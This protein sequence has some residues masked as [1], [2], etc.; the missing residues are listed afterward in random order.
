MNI[1][2]TLQQTGLYFVWKSF[3]RS[4]FIFLNILLSV[5]IESRVSAFPITEDPSS[6]MVFQHIG[7]NGKYILGYVCHSE[8]GCNPY[9]WFKGQARSLRQIY[10]KTSAKIIPVDCSSDGRIV[11]GNVET[12]FTRKGKKR[13]LPILWLDGNQ[14]DL[15]H[16][17]GQKISGVLGCSCD[18]KKIIGYAYLDTGRTL[19]MWDVDYEKCISTI[20]ELNPFSVSK[21]IIDKF[22]TI[23]LLFELVYYDKSIAQEIISPSSH[24]IP[25]MYLPKF[26]DLF[27]KYF[28]SWIE[29]NIY[30]QKNK[31][32]AN[33]NHY[34]VAGY[35]PE[36]NI[37]LLTDNR[38]QNKFVQKDDEITLVEEYLMD[39]LGDKLN[40]TL[41]P[42][43]KWIKFSEDASVF[44][45]NRRFRRSVY[46]Q[47]PYFEILNIDHPDTI[48]HI[49]DISWD[50]NTVI[51][52]AQTRDSKTL[53][54]RDIGVIWKTAYEKNWCLE[55]EGNVEL[56][57]C[58]RQGDEMV[59]NQMVFS[60]ELDSRGFLI[61]QKGLQYLADSKEYACS[62]VT[63]M[64]KLNET[65]I[66][67][68][69]YPYDETK[70]FQRAVVWMNNEMKYLE[71]PS[72]ICYS[73]ANIC[74]DDGNWIG[75]A[76]RV[77]VAGDI[78]KNDVQKTSECSHCF[79]LNPSE[80]ERSIESIPFCTEISMSDSVK[81]RNSSTE[82]D[83]HIFSFDGLTF[84]CL[85]NKDNC[86][87]LPLLLGS[88]SGEIL[89]IVSKKDYLDTKKR[90]VSTLTLISEINNKVMKWDLNIYDDRINRSYTLSYEVM[91]I[92]VGS[93]RCVSKCGNW[94]GGKYQNRGY[95]WNKRFGM[96]YLSDILQQLDIPGINKSIQNR[97]ITEINGISDDLDVIVGSAS[98]VDHLD[99]HSSF[100]C[101]V[102]DI[103]RNDSFLIKLKSGD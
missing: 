75:G 4:L 89:Y 49:N 6:N 24:R 63:S 69:I 56:I 25:R 100:K 96:I 83:N 76:V 55:L 66:G 31:T 12:K 26:N 41:I 47:V 51:G 79:L 64:S 87:I 40:L 13:I 22:P 68:V 85:W 71:A 90:K 70:P 50:G 94:I 86:Y 58:T 17:T 52:I 97:V 45:G 95:L 38:T 3:L 27:I 32:E 67:E 54:G 53:K 60:P 18:G 28:N 39:Y 2:Y 77:N 92:K 35:A 48:T 81:K 30:H 15:A 36:R 1:Q 91:P 102:F 9:I 21:F 29:E 14:Q 103:L 44:I 62:L 57:S 20:E 19:C 99:S 93:M 98:P 10:S 80:E 33:V 37:L 74:S 84:P 43:T 59:G 65:V 61:S 42:E 88:T 34:E 72:E 7:S 8:G 16:L 78:D 23:Q 11:V 46:V 101:K 5:S 73:R 82:K